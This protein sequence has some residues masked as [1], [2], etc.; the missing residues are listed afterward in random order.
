MGYFTAAEIASEI[1]SLSVSFPAICKRQDMSPPTFSLTHDGKTMSYLKIGNGVGPNRPRVLITTG[2]HAREWVPPNAMLRQVRRLLKAYTAGTDIAIPSFTDPVTSI[3]YPAFNL[4]LPEI[5]RI[6][7]TLDLYYVPL[8]NPDG[9]AFTLAVN[10]FAHTNW[11]K[12]RR[13]PSPPSADP[14]CV[15]VDLNRNFDIAFD[16]NSYYSTVAAAT[17]P[18]FTNSCDHDLFHGPSAASEPETQNIV[19]LCNTESIQFSLDIH[20]FGRLLFFP[21]VTE[22]TQDADKDKNFHNPAWDRSGANGGRDIV[23]GG[24]GEFFPNDNPLKLRTTHIL[25]ANRMKQAILKT[26]G[27]DAN[28]QAN[29]TYKVD[30]GAALVGISP[31]S[32]MDWIFS[33]Q[34]RGL[35]TQTTHCFAMECGFADDG[36]FQPDFVKK[37][38]KVEREVIAAVHAYLSFISTWQPPKSSSSTCPCFIATAA[39]GSAHHPHVEFLRGLRDQAFRETPFGA[40][41]IEAVER[42]Y[43]RFSP[44]IARYLH[45]HETAR[46]FTRYTFL[47]PLVTLLRGAKRAA[48][49]TQ[50]PR[51]K[52][53]LLAS[54][55]LFALL[56]MGALGTGLLAG[57][58]QA[59]WLLFT[60]A[61][62]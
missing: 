21:W 3:T 34:F 6:I 25:V 50:N 54:A 12:N 10:D 20:S 61:V 35:T 40:R 28:A 7:E 57:I 1:V 59:L 58:V 46:R 60:F 14:D 23:G 4:P 42:V 62:R 53:G 31:G 22:D 37:F 11:R 18:T 44:A 33:R 39:F 17:L 19:K 51:V 41:F 32:M 8:V 15:G 26:A 29:S 36:G 2:I 16:I 38:P 5:K 24:Y 47:S 52:V 45:R 56:L 55:V 9:F 27:A 49:R 13:P 30:H 48:D 43:Y